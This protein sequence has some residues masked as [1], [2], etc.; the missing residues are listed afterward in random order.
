M[1]SD[2]STLISPTDAQIERSVNIK[3]IVSHLKAVRP[4]IH[5]G[6]TENRKRAWK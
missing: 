4:I 1:R 6:V 3:E 2:K 5:D